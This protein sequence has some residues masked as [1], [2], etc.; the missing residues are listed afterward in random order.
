MSHPGNGKGCR[1]LNLHLPTSYR[2]GILLVPNPTNESPTGRED[3]VS[4]V[5]PAECT[6]NHPV[7][8]LPNLTLQQGY[9]GIHPL[10][11]SQYLIIFPISHHSPHQLPSGPEMPQPPDKVYKN[12]YHRRRIFFSVQ[13]RCNIDSIPVLPS[14]YPESPTFR[15]I[16]LKLRSHSRPFDPP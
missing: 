15:H 2:L 6:E 11:S 14:L 16:L 1:M 5:P 9:A 10:F 4:C 8:G 12:R 3:A 7:K 13:R